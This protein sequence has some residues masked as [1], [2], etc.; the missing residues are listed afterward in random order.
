MKDLMSERGVI[1]TTS[2][3]VPI[4]NRIAEMIGVDKAKKGTTSNRQKQL[5]D[6]VDMYFFGER[7]KSYKARIFGKDV[8]ISKVTSA[9]AS[10]TALNTL[11]LNYMQATNQLIMDNYRLMEEAAAG[12]FMTAK[13]LLKAKSEYMKHLGAIKD[14]GKIDPKSPLAKYLRYVDA[15]QNQEE[16]GGRPS[17]GAKIKKVPGEVF[18]GFQSMAEAETAITRAIAVGYNIKVKLADG[19]TTNLYDAYVDNK[20]LK[21]AKQVMSDG[22]EVALNRRQVSNILGGIYK[23]TNQLK[24]DFNRVA[25]ERIPG[26]DLVLLF[27][28]FMVPSIRRRFGHGGKESLHIDAEL[29][30]VTQGMYISFMNYLIERVRGG[31]VGGAG[32]FKRL[33]DVEKANVKR[34]MMEAGGALLSLLA[35]TTLANMDDEEENDTVIFWAYQMRRLQLELTAFNPVSFVTSGEALRLLKSPTAG[36]RSL[37]R[38]QKLLRDLYNYTGYQLG[39]DVEEKD[40]FYQRSQGKYEK[41]DLKLEASFDKFVIGRAGLLQSENAREALKWFNQAPI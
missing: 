18:M 8:S 7:K 35:Y 30:T 34:T 12:E 38:L 41:G 9:I 19:T 5:N 13:G 37:S 11:S 15:F 1:E 31:I 4:V 16:L 6:F 17:A 28:K 2:S 27:R 3:G 33:S 26:L 40:V 39:L 22:S 23:R 32:T 21:G 36:V 24:G 20:D 10:F 25:A 14:V 29:G